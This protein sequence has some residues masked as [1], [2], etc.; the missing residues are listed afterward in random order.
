MGSGCNGKS[1]LH[2]RASLPSKATSILLLD[3]HRIFSLSSLTS[4]VS[5]QPSQ[6][7]LANTT[8]EYQPRFD[9]RYSPHHPGASLNP[10]AP[11]P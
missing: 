2:G 6:Q 1:I 5:L 7:P 10:S 4:R 11:S 8:S 9:R 3:H